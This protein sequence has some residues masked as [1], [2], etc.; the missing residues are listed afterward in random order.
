[1]PLHVNQPA[2][3]CAAA[4]LDLLVEHQSEVL[5]QVLCG[6][7]EVGLTTRQDMHPENKQFQKQVPENSSA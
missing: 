1:M 6:V 4:H 3:V 5:L 2:V 7:E